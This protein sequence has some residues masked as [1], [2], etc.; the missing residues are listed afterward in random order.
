MVFQIRTEIADAA[1]SW[2]TNE[3]SRRRTWKHDRDDITVLD[4]GS[5]ISLATAR[6]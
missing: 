1:V 5:M 6:H 2:P 3:A 4:A